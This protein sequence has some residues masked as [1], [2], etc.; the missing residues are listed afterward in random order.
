M[1]K[2]AKLP[3]DDVRWV[4]LKD[5][6]PHRERQTGD[7][8][9]A[10]ADMQHAVP[11]IRTMKR[12]FDNRS[13]RTSAE[14]LTRKFWRDFD[15]RRWWL[16]SRTLNPFPENAALYV[17]APDLEKIWPERAVEAGRQVDVAN[18]R[19]PQRRRGPAT[20]HD[21][22]AICG[23][24]ARRCIDPTTGRVRM[25]KSELKLAEHVLLWCQNEYGKEP[26]ESE[27]REAVKRVCAAL[28]PLQK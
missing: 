20:T 2:R 5:I 10:L 18:T 12:S 27:V 25:P 11:R 15:W 13:G 16:S 28:R 22:H 1:T 24:I 9:L 23:E 17:W 6:L 4:P 21:Y 8:K 26:A 3:L 19:P 14:L 7:G